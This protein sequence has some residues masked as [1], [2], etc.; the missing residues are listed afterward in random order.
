MNMKALSVS[1]NDGLNFEFFCPEL[2]KNIIVPAGVNGHGSFNAGEAIFGHSVDGHRLK[3]SNFKQYWFKNCLLKY[4]GILEEDET[5]VQGE[6]K[7][8]EASSFKILAE[9]AWYKLTLGVTDPQKEYYPGFLPVDVA[10][11]YGFPTDCK[12]KGQSIA[13]ISLQGKMDLIELAKDFKKLGFKKMPDISTFDV[14]TIPA[15]QDADS[16]GETHLDVEV[17]GSICPEAKITVYRGDIAGTGFADTVNKAVKDKST[18][19]SI[20]WGGN[21]YSS[22]SASDLEVALAAA[23]KA[24]ITVCVAT[25]DGGSSNKRDGN[26]AVA[27]SD[28]KAHIQFPACSKNVLACGGTQIDTVDGVKKEIVWNNAEKGGGSGGGGVSEFIDLPKWQS[29]YKIDIKSANG[30]KHVGRVVPDVSG[31]AA[32][33]KDADWSIFEDG[34]KRANGGTSAVAPLWASLIAIANE[35]RGKLKKPKGSL[36]FINDSLYKIAQSKGHFLDIVEGDNRPLPNYPGYDATEGYDACTGLGSPIADKIIEALV[37]LPERVHTKVDVNSREA[38][39][40][41]FVEPMVAASGASGVGGPPNFP[42]PDLNK[43]FSD[44]KPSTT[45][46]SWRYVYPGVNIE[47]HCSS[48]GKTPIIPKGMVNHVDASDLIFHNSCPQCNAKLKAKDSTGWWAYKCRFIYDGLLS[49]DEEDVKGD[50]AFLDD[51]VHKTIG[52]PVNYYYL[53]ITTQPA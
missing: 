43:G 31:M 10:K 41:E 34:A 46:P 25:G 35:K 27:D 14:G 23:T 36:G 7:F 47:Y 48:C 11:Y 13:V 2:G 30:G 9:K 19:I 39:S 21:E 50:Q 5:E 33:I 42:A 18:V 4:D 44:V 38:V 12:G 20:S 29:A 28:N 22:F 1:C 16:T 32:F 53:K 3:A 45:G 51:N 52:D 49:P 8:G 6:E 40:P 24:G 26:K 15:G 37:D 17:I